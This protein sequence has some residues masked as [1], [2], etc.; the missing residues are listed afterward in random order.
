MN[1]RKIVIAGG[2]CSGKTTLIRELEQHGFAVL[3]E[4]AIAIIT[5]LNHQFGIEG[6][7]QW[8]RAHQEEFQ[9]MVTQQQAQQEAQA[10]PHTHLLFCDRGRHDAIAYFRLYALSIPDPIRLLIEEA[11]YDRVFLLDTLTTFSQRPETGRTSDRN[12]S[13]QIRDILYEVYR[14]YGYDPVWVPE[15]PVQG[16]IDMVLRHLEVQ[17]L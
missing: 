11:D 2:P 8:R 16:R 3:P 4:A 17:E 9:L 14:E 5:E 7:K 13:L 10:T 6:Q 12:A 1:A 15:L